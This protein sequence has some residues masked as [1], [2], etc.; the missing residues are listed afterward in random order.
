MSKFSDI[1][2]QKVVGLR[3]LFLE[4]QEGIKGRIEEELTRSLL[5]TGARGK[6]IC[7]PGPAIEQHLERLSPIGKCLFY[8]IDHN[9][10]WEIQSKISSSRDCLLVEGD[11][12]DKAKGECGVA[13][14]DIDHISPFDSVWIQSMQLLASLGLKNRG[15]IRITGSLRD[16]QARNRNPIAY[17]GELQAALYAKRRRVSEFFSKVYCSGKGSGSPMLAIAANFDRLLPTSY[18][19]RP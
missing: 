8:E 17:M 19:M 1:S 11:V 9:I 5:L 13:L 10:L 16:K 3:N 2:P 15:Q 7:L 6:V 4:K 18:K 14:L 12:F